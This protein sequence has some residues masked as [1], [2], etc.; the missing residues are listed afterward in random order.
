MSVYQR[1]LRSLCLQ[2][3]MTTSENM[4]VNIELIDK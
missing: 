4:I 2:N 3:S 1:V